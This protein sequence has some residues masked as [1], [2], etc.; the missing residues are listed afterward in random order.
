MKHLKYTLI[1]LAVISISC[2]GDKNKS[3]INELVNEKATT[4]TVIKTSK[5]DID[6]IKEK[7]CYEFPNEL[8]LGYNPDANYIEIEP[9]DNGSGGI[10]HCNVKL[11]YGEKDYE[12]WHGQ[13]F[14]NINEMKDPF[15]QY[16]PER[17]ATLYQKVDGLGEKAVYI[18][19]MYQLLI[20]KEGVIYS[21]VPPNRGSNTN[22]GKQTKAIA[23]EIA[24]HYGL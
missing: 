3:N 16:N 15:W 6:K 17:N 2:L 21:I 22:S 23:L 14:A 1:L 19:N 20:L 8:I 9:V 5:I 10:L 4:N 24:K 12:Y 18:S 11:F 7:L 13:V